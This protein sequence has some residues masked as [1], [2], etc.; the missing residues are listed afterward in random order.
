MR[1]GMNQQGGCPGRICCLQ[2]LAPAV[3][4][5]IAT[6]AKQVCRLSDYMGVRVCLQCEMRLQV[7]VSLH[8]RPDSLWGLFLLCL[9]S[10]SQHK[11]HSSFKVHI[12]LVN[13]LP[14]FST[15]PL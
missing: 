15:S 14:L 11:V 4:Q 5:S 8:A 9:V 7:P 3:T 1:A 10:G 6:S 12:R 13:T 2:L